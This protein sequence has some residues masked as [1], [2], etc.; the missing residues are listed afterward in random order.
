MQQTITIAGNTQQPL[1]VNRLGY[2]T[3]RLTGEGVYGEPPRRDEALQI[4]KH[5]VNNGVNFLDTADYYGDDV[6]N[7]LI[8]EAVFPYTNDLVICTKV[9]ASR[10][11]DK[12]W[13]PFNKPEQLRIAI[14]KNLQTLQI[15]QVQLVHFR[16]LPGSGVPFKESLDAMF[17]MQQE[18]K[19]LHVGVSNVNREELETA[20]QMGNIATVENMYGHGQRTTIVSPYGENRGGEEIL[21][22]CE[23]NNIPLIPYFSLVNSLSKK[24][25]RIATI[26]EKYKASAAQIN[27]AWLLHRSPWILPIPGTSSLEHCKENLAA[28]SIQLSKAD[29]EFLN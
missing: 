25:N 6:T 10:K 1:S 23:A 14:D 17:E 19:I 24:D 11:P 2:G 4:L 12:S 8:K 22:I 9:G 21:D 29:M 20:M 7:R 28:A 15:E 26:A 16:V 13:I 5:V 27:I 3:M 18:G